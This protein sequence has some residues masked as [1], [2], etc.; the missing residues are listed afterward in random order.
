MPKNTGRDKKVVKDEQPAKTS[1]HVEPQ[2]E[3]M[4]PQ[5]ISAVYN[6]N[7]MLTLYVL[8]EDG[9]IMFK[10]EDED[11]WQTTQLGMPL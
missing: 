9:S 11:Q 10:R 5:G 2:A 1:D 8:M 3:R 7:G 6:K 4:K